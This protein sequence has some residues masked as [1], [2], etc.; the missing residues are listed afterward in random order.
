MFYVL[1]ICTYIVSD[2]SFICQVRIVRL[3]CVVTFSFNDENADD[4]LRGIQKE[5]MGIIRL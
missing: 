4:K 5:R 1:Y 2:F 3:V